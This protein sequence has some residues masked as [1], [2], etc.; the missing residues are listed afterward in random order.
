MSLNKKV[1]AAAIVGTLFAAGN[2]AAVDFTV[3][4]PGSAA[5]ANTAGRYAKEIRIDT[6]N[7]TTFAASAGNE[8]VW[9]LGQN[10][11]PGEV[12]YVRIEAAPHVEFRAANPTTTPS[13][14]GNNADVITGSVN[15]VGTNVI[16]FSITA[17][18]T[19]TVGDPTDD[20]VIDLPASFDLF[21]SAGSNVKVSLYDTASQAQQGGNAGL[22]AF[23]SFEGPYFSFANS[24]RWTGT[25]VGATA[26]VGAAPS[27]T[28]FTA[29]GTTATLTTALA[30]DTIT[31]GT[32]TAAGGPV[33][34][35]TLVSA[36]NSSVTI[37]GDF[38]FIRSSNGA[39]AY[40][41]AARGRANAFG[42]TPAASRLSADSAEFS[43]ATAFTG[44]VTLGAKLT[45][46]FNPVIAASGYTARLNAVATTPATYSVPVLA[47]RA[48]GA[49]DRN[50]VTLQ[51][52]L[53]QSPKD[54]ISRLVLTN[55][56]GVERPYT[57]TVMT[58][59]GVTA[60]TGTL[61]GVIPANGTKV[62]D[63]LKDVFTTGENQPQRGTLVVDVAARGNDV[64]GLY[65]I[66]NPASGS[67]SNHVMVR[68]NTN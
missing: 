50:G 13:A 5:V 58:E 30:I 62:I 53:V 59:E 39:T 51:A 21:E 54:W 20:V 33:T 23:G 68:P 46:A 2:A 47:D 43:L 65:Q 45:G 40:D 28:T 52:P 48:L 37:L 34:V 18:P 3:G 16:T 29:A 12:K 4:A 66:V 15:G 14:V 36:A 61:T 60:T 27:Y 22:N 19:N 6:A 7:G 57:I 31:G 42:T 17:D 9:N 25:N 10:L 49:I 35:G 38:S 64:Q 11:S 24:L 63:D 41:A 56:S 44:N 67:I 55:T 8:I 1:L 32:L 26:D